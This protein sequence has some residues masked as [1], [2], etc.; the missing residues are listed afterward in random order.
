MVLF[1]LVYGSIAILGM[2]AHSLLDWLARV[3]RTAVAV[4]AFLVSAVGAFGASFV[5]D[6]W[7]LVPFGTLQSQFLITPTITWSAVAITAV[8]VSLGR[9]VSRWINALPFFLL[10]GVAMLATFVHVRHAITALLLLAAA[11]MIL[12]LPSRDLSAAS[13]VAP[14]SQKQQRAVS[15][16]VGPYALGAKIDALNGLVVFT[17]AEYEALQRDMEFKNE[18]IYHAPDATF[19]GLSWSIILGA[20]DGRVYKISALAEAANVRESDAI[21][22]KALQFLK[23]HLGNPAVSELNLYLWDTE[24]GNVILNA[25]PALGYHAVTLTVTSGAVRGFTRVK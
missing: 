23:S 5:I 14:S 3:N 8:A 16:M 17:P 22:G 13:P 9:G 10:G 19:T 24:D 11:A 15:P 25:A 21:L 12:S 20:V 1:V 4:V 2:A 6:F 18:H 7:L